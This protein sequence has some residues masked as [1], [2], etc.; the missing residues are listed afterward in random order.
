MTKAQEIIAKYLDEMDMDDPGVHASNILFRLHKAGIDAQA[1]APCGL[2]NEEMENYRMAL[3]YISRQSTDQQSRE[4]A[5]T[6]LN[7]FPADRVPQTSKQR[8]PGDEVVYFNGRLVTWAEV[9]AAVQE[10]KCS[11]TR[12]DRN[13]G[14]A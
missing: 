14:E 11:H 13:K 8:Q 6:A 5:E 10:W 9:E 12:P 7:A 2:N 3:A 4:L 1:D